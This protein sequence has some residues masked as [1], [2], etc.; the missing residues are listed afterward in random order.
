MTEEFNGLPGIDDYLN[1]NG[2]G[3]P[4][5]ISELSEFIDLITANS[6][7]D[8]KQAKRVLILFFHNIRCL[9]L[10]GKSVNVNNLG[11]FKPYASY[12]HNKVAKIKFKPSKNLRNK[13][14]GK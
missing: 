8:K 5:N 4:V 9:L 10:E 7:L 3:C 13:I 2:N 11:V 14:N 12:N 6:I 1:Q